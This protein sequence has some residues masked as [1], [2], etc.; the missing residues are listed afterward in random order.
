MSG[1]MVPFSDS[2]ILVVGDLM[3]DRYW[4]GD[5]A[6]I[7]PEAPVPVVRVTQSED[8]V[9]GAANVARNIRA[10][11]GNAE[12]AGVVGADDNGATLV[13][14]LEEAGCTARVVT[15]EGWETITKLRVLSR[16]QQLIRLDFEQ[17]LA[18]EAVR[19]QAR[20][21]EGALPATD[22]VV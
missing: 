22:I 13:S 14:L 12:V 4:H 10:L 19:S 6:R 20:A 21:F 7:S 15:W 5:T 16:H 1:L 2:R 8:R 11:G 17:S 18:P 9:G 3:L